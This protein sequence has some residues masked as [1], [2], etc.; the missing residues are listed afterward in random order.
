MS[1]GVSAQQALADLKSRP[2]HA[3]STIDSTVRPNP[4]AVALIG[5][6]VAWLL[7][8]SRRRMMEE[9]PLAAGAVGFM[10]GVAAGA[11]LP[12]TVSENRPERDRLMDEAA[13]DFRS[14]RERATQFTASTGQTRG[15]AP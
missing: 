14:E 7:T 4:L 8:G 10:L 3:S 2:S 6:G 9:H 1:D 13:R 15:T 11:A 12:R 5:A